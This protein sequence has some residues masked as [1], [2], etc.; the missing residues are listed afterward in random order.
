[1]STQSPPSNAT[2]SIAKAQTIAPLFHSPHDQERFERN[3]EQFI[4]QHYRNG[5]TRP[6]DEILKHFLV[7]QRTGG[8]QAQLQQAVQRLKQNT[9][10]L[11]AL[12]RSQ[13]LRHKLRKVSGMVLSSAHTP[14]LTDTETTQPETLL[15]YPP[16]NLL[17][18]YYIPQRAA[19][20][21]A[22]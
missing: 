15:P 3:L 20:S 6:L 7:Y 13:E 1:M 19:V 8:Q 12:I 22:A 11:H 9:S 16:A 2:L 14:E 10:A 21:Q 18:A 5:I 4:D 17:Q